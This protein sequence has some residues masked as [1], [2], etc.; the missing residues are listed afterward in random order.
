VSTLDI[1][2]GPHGQPPQFTLFVDA[3]HAAQADEVGSSSSSRV[4]CNGSGWDNGC[5]LWVQAAQ[6]LQAQAPLRVAVVV[7]GPAAACGAPAAVGTGPDAVRGISI[8]SF[9]DVQGLWHERTGLPA[10]SALLV[11]PD[12]HVAWRR[13]GPLLPTQSGTRTAAAAAEGQLGQQAAVEPALR[14]LRRVL[15][16]VLGGAAER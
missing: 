2:S 5:V 10:G 7:P 6:Q 3:S 13:V 4:S 9:A 14:A 15:R 12:G 8:S 11:R 16:Q 1:V